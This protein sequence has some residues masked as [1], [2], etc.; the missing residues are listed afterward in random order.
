MR[1]LVISNMYPSKQKPYSGLFVVNQVNEIKKQLPDANIDFFYLKRSFTSKKGT[2]LKYLFFAVRFLKYFFKPKYEILHVHYYF[3]TIYLA[4]FYKKLINKKV[5]IIVTFHGGD[6]YMQDVKS[7]IY[8]FPFQFIDKIICVSKNLGNHLSKEFNIKEPI[9][10]SAGINN[11][12]SP[13]NHFVKKKYDLIYVG[14][15][16]TQKG[17]DLFCKAVNLCKNNLSICI[18][19]SGYLENNITEIHSIHSIKLFKNL[20]QEQILPLIHTSKYLINT[21]REESF[22]LSMAEAMASGTPVIATST[23][24]SQQQVRDSKNGFLTVDK[25]LESIAKTIDFALS[26]GSEDYDTLRQNA[27]ID[28]QKQNVNSIVT[29]LNELYREIDISKSVNR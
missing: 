29:R 23:D 12:F 16:Y 13:P 9:I 19:G 20:T 1:V 17:F 18:V 24:G 3:P 7:Y 28:G 27:I 15:F 22:G 26:L 10:L 6:Y 4:I 5:N 21:S 8:V 2:V 11:I 14:S 25:S